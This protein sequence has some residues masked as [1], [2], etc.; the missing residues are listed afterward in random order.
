M[1]LP[2]S[3]T[4][5]PRRHAWFVRS[6]DLPRTFCAGKSL[7]PKKKAPGLQNVP[8]ATAAA[9]FQTFRP[10]V[11]Q[12]N[13]EQ[14][15]QPLTTKNFVEPAKLPP[16]IVLEGEIKCNGPVNLEVQGRADS[17]LDWNLGAKVDANFECKGLA[18]VQCGAGANLDSSLGANFGAKLDAEIKHKDLG[19]VH[20][21]A[22]ANLDSSSGAK[23]NGEIDVEVN[24]LGKAGLTFRDV[25]NH[26]RLMGFWR[27][28]R[29]TFSDFY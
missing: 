20:G 3:V 28:E 19:K 21:R 8:A 12:N 4:S 23:V 9:D 24:G 15:F 26:H 2:L 5:F 14:N 6:L 10:S 17:N 27:L 18:K 13:L 1:R 29:N 11:D 25:L 7:S 16:K 22:D